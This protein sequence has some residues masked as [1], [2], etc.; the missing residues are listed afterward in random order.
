MRH[1][2]PL[3]TVAASLT[4]AVLGCLCFQA[5]PAQ[6]KPDTGGLILAWEAAQ[7][8]D[9]NTEVFRK[10]GE[11]TYHFK[12]KLFPFEGELRV[13]NAFI[14]DRRTDPENDYGGL[15]YGVVT[16]ELVGAPAD[17][18]QKHSM[19]YSVWNAGNTLFWS[20]SKGRWTTS[21]EFPSVFAKERGGA[22]SNWLFWVA[23]YFW[24]ILLAFLI[25]IILLVG[26]RTKL[27]MRKAF[28]YQ[29]RAQASIERSLAL[30][31]RSVT[32][33]EDSNRVLREIL[34]TLRKGETPAPAPPPENPPAQTG[35]P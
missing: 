21:R 26:R 23:D 20:D 18:F 32:L 16:V 12:T 2:K 5:A 24:F 11:Q 3:P 30:S 28:D 31:E 4:L 35:T 1:P 33:A 10:T 27:Q 8:A 14:D 6:S 17:L 19:A 13:L 15:I 22:G 25:F 34:A 29:D 9:R 7:K